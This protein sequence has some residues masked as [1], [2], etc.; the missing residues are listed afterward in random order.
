MPL[1]SDLLRRSPGAAFPVVPAAP[2]TELLVTYLPGPSG[3]PEPVGNVLPGATVIRLSALRNREPVVDTFRIIAWR[4]PT[5]DGLYP[6]PVVSEDA[7]MR[8]D[9]IGPAYCACGLKFI[10]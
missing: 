3:A 9:R 1:F 10:R 7:G 2:E 6:I 4:V 8:L 5:V